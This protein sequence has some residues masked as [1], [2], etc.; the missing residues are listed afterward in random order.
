MFPE[1][2]TLLIWDSIN[3]VKIENKYVDRIVNL[4]SNKNLI[5]SKNYYITLTTY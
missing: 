2:T 1:T 3:R 4:A 5:V